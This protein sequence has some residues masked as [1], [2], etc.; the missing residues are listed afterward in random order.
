MN[1]KYSTCMY[2]YSIYQD[3]SFVTHRSDQNLPLPLSEG[4]SMIFVL[5]LSLICKESNTK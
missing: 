2:T 4:K 5:F 3:C 1:I